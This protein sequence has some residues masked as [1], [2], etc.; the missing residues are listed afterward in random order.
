M[1]SEQS[2]DRHEAS[3]SQD[4]PYQATYGDMSKVIDT[5]RGADA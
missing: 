5:T 4:A 2:P 3:L 1:G